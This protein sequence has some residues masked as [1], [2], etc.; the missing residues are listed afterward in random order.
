MIS[1]GPVSALSQ[2]KPKYETGIKRGGNAYL[3]VFTAYFFLPMGNTSLE[4]SSERVKKIIV[5]RSE[6]KEELFSF[7]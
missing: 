5:L 7:K 4:Y 1:L 3:D 6:L 2:W